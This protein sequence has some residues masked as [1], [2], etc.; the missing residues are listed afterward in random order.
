MRL[1][2]FVDEVP[3][4]GY[5]VDCLVA[6]NQ[7]VAH[8]VGYVI[9]NEPGIQTSEET[10]ELGRGSCRDSALLL[11]DVLRSRG[12][13]ARFVSGYLIQL[14]DEGI[15]PDEAKGVSFDVVDLHAWAEVYLPG[16]GWIGLDGTSGLLC[17]EGHIPLASVVDP[18]LAAPIS[19]TSSEA[20]EHFSFSMVVQRIGHEP[21]PRTPYADDEWEGIAAAGDRV[22]R[23]LKDAGIGLTCGGEPTW[24]SRLHPDEPEWNTEAQGP[25]K[26]AQGLVFARELRERL[27][28]G[29]V[30]MHRFGKHYPGE[31]LPRWALHLIWRDD[32]VP[33]W[34][35]PSSLTLSEN[36]VGAQTAQATQAERSAAAPAQEHEA[37][38][39]LGKEVASRLGVEPNL[40]PGFED[41]WRFIREEQDLPVDIDPFEADLDDPEERQRLARALERGLG[42]PVG[43]A[44]P[45]QQCD[46]QWMTGAWTFRRGRMFLVPGDS[47]M[48]LRLPLERLPGYAPGLFVED[49]TWV[50]GPFAFT[51]ASPTIAA[52]A[53]SPKA[54]QQTVEQSFGS[55][56]VLQTALCFEARGGVLRA[57]LPPLTSAE[58]FLE[59]V[60]TIEDAARELGMPVH[61]E[62]YPPP[63]DPRLRSCLVTPDPGVIEVNLPVARTFHEYLGWMET[64][65][66]AANHA[67]LCTEKYQLDG[68]EVGS[69]GGNHL[70]LGGEEP[71]KSPFIER[72]ELLASLLRYLQHH[73]ALSYLFTGL[74]VGPTSQ[75]PRIDEARMDSLEQLELALA[76]VPKQGEPSFPW[77]IDRLLRNL[78]V[79][80]AGNTH[81]TEVCIDKLFAPEGPQGR[82]GLVELRA[83]EMPPNE[84]MAAVQMLL[85]RALIARFALEPYDRPLIAWGTAL[86]DRFMLPYYLERDMRD[87]VEDLR[88]VGL[89]LEALWFRP[90]L[91]YRLPVFGRLTLEEIEVELRSALEP[92]PA[93][94]EQPVGGAVAR[95][96][97][98]SLER[99]QVRARGLI[100]GRHRISVN[101]FELPMVP[102]DTVGESIAGLRFRAWQPP[103]CLQPAIG[104]HHPL[105]FDVV[106]TWADRSLGACTYHVWHPEGRAFEQPPLTAFE[107]AARRAQRFTTEGHQPYPAKV[108][109]LPSRPEHPVTFDLRWA[110]MRNA[111][112]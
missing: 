23:V 55:G 106:D 44:L 90:F 20:V 14:R 61:I 111:E 94:G 63:P 25:T 108:E 105:R 110:S 36:A 96:V 51:P 104:V 95:Y 40:V 72:P 56:A 27:G 99:L 45:I 5:T 19:G 60:A 6:L 18:K 89:Q 7:A 75:A 69:G 80:V 16:A 91:D 31:S 85:A 97:D 17:G 71:L 103:F 35:D 49:T 65:S 2:R 24:T 3:L 62:G 48:G 100:P 101:G 81:R 11:C 30:V 28:I 92:W 109:R 37:A 83:F 66:D 73:P 77:A 47:P 78:L 8:R 67:G 50:S 59:L 86:H 38:L 74:F 21:S 43:Y 54:G 13:A 58:S 52:S 53:S 10:L 34:R 70:T 84:R 76:Q 26:W 41:P 12:L 4:E 102:T 9:R 32:G 39:A 87:V 68:R 15:V 46:A 88:R 29:T 98:F 33:I 1:A 112:R 64:L 79:D 107:A 82:L 93:L 42:Q 22:D 57:F